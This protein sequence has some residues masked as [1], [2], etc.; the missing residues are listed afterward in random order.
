MR[1]GIFSLGNSRRGKSR[2]KGH[3]RNW[4]K[5]SMFCG[6]QGREWVRATGRERENPWVR[7]QYWVMRGWKIR[8]ERRGKEKSGKL[9]RRKEGKK[10][11]WKGGQEEGQRERE[12]KG[13]SVIGRSMETERLMF[14]GARASWE[15][16]SNS[17]LG[18]GFPFGVMEIFWN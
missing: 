10:E 12:R 15:M 4:K 5:G 16:G 8:E 7:S 11:S 18:M 6:E 17:L 14:P 3:W 1:A 2:G 13:R 9:E